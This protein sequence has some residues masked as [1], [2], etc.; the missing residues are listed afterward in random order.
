MADNS[1]ARARAAADAI[2]DLW[3]DKA[4]EIDRVIAEAETG[5]R[6]GVNVKVGIRFKLEKFEGE[7]APGK[8]PYEVIE[9]RDNL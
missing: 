6:D 2:R 8:A 7:A 1:I 5:K 9:G 3:P 4:A